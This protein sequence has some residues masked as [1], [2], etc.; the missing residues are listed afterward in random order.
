[1]R[2]RVG[3]TWKAPHLVSRSPGEITPASPKSVAFN[4]DPRSS[5]SNR[6]L[7]G[8]MSRKIIPRL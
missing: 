4:G 2:N 1:M 6:K 5:R 3:G 8:F 7:S